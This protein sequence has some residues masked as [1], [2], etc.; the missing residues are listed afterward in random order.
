MNCKILYLTFCIFLF[1]TA[2]KKTQALT[3]NINIKIDSIF[4]SR[5]NYRTTV[6]IYGN[7]FDKLPSNYFISINDLRCNIVTKTNTALTIALPARAGS[8]KFQIHFNNETKSS[9]DFIFEKIYLVSTIAGDGNIGLK[10]GQGTNARFF[11]PVSIIKD[12]KGD[13]LITDY[14][15]HVIRKMDKN[16]NVT[17]YA[18]TGIS[19]YLDGDKTSAKFSYPSG[20]V[21]DK[22]DNLYIA[23][24][25]NH[26][27]RKIS[28][29]G[30]VST[31]AGSTA[32]YLDGNANIAKF[33]QPKGIVMDAFGNIFIVDYNND[34]IRKLSPNGIVETYAGSSKGFTD[35]IGVAAKFNFPATIACDLNNVLYVADASNNRIRKIDNNR[36]VTTLAGDGTVGLKDGLLS[37]CKLNEPKGVYLDNHQN[38][39]IGD[40]SNH[41]VR[42]I[43]GDSISTIIGSTQ[44][45]LD[46]EN[47]NVKFNFPGGMLFE[48]DSTILMCDV[49]NQR[50]RKIIIR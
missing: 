9:T 37:T 38:V 50:I 25:Y 10:D 26:K 7:D 32:G 34:R 24:T 44:G 2:C 6:I 39:W 35:G 3:A 33:N 41:V 23:D 46:G 36:N 19:G 13:Y 27:I 30:L 21:I 4:P 22:N 47:K 15:N 31:I 8:G 1:N 14:F 5:G 16:Y 17:T 45:F 49:H 18:G 12:S 28:T 48:N 20:T 40:F 29:N 42:Y 43:D 11:Y